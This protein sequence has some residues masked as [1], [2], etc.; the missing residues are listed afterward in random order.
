MQEF[1]ELPGQ[2]SSGHEA[3]GLSYRRSSHE[4]ARPASRNL[5]GHDVSLGHARTHHGSTTLRAGATRAFVLQHWS[6][7]EDYPDF[8]DDMVLVSEDRYHHFDV[9]GITWQPG[10]TMTYRRVG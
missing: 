5:G 2:Q 1:L 8:P 6:W 3:Q 10:F 9:R 4:R 7:T